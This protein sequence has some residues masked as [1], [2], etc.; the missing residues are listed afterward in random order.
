MNQRQARRQ[1]GSAEEGYIVGYFGS[2]APWQGLDILVESAGKVIEG[3]SQSV[4][5]VLVG[6]GQGRRELQQ[7]VD[8]LGL[9][10]YFTFLP[11][12]P[13]EQVAVFNNACDVTVIPVHDLAQASVWFGPAKILGCCLCWCSGTCAGGLSVG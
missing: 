11:P 13:F 10:Q 4:Q 8:Q 3:S 9:S 12:V 1:L 5:F 2:F 6:E 7:M